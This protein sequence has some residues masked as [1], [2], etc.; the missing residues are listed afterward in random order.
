[1]KRNLAK[2]FSHFIGINLATRDVLEV[3]EPEE[4]ID[5]L[6]QILKEI[7]SVDPATGLPKGDIAYFLSKDG[8]P[9]V[10]AWLESNLLSPRSANGMQDPAKVSDDL[11]VEMSRKSDETTEGYASR[12]MSIYDEAQ[13]N[14]DKLRNSQSSKTD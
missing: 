9:Q 14:I 6:H 12:L 8:N 13:S 10:K 4:I 2:F 5:E 3:Q 11:I 1:M 7:F